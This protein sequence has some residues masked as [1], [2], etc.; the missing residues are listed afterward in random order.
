MIATG[1]AV[2]EQA[3]PAVGPGPS[4]RYGEPAEVADA[5]CWLLSDASSYVNGTCL[6]VDGGWSALASPR[7][8]RSARA[9]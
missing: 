6:E 4:G 9:A 1:I 7:Q 8:Q 3:A 5:V 2:A